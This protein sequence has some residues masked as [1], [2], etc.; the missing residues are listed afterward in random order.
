ME[1]K[2]II[3]TK[4]T[5]R[6]AFIS[7][8][9]KEPFEKI[10]VTEIC[11]VGEISRITFY[12]YYDDK[13]QLVEEMMELYNKEADDDYHELMKKE[14]T[15]P[16][17]GY[18]ILMVC[19]LNLYHNNLDFFRYATPS[20]NPYLYSAF[21]QRIFRSTVSYLERHTA[22]KTRFHVKQTAALL[23]NGL[24]SMINESYSLG[25]DEKAVTKDAMTVFEAL[26]RSQLF[27]WP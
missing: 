9:K 24:W 6:N 12:N 13:Y 16:L 17:G 4:R 22:L 19:I 10:T 3:K 15:S 20:T 18:L 23:C 26:L 1:D 27:L 2:R 14:Q 5:I 25:M 21:S 11:E 7:L 8:L